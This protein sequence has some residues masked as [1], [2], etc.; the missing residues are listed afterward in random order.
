VEVVHMDGVQIGIPVFFVYLLYR[1]RVPTLARRKKRCHQLR[2]LLDT[3]DRESHGQMDELNAFLNSET[4][5]D[6]TYAQVPTMV[7]EQVVSYLDLS[8][9]SADVDTNGTLRDA[10]HR[11][12]SHSTFSGH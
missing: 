11:G 5:D 2:R 7:L 9:V 12:S 6:L 3:V 1:Y 10:P 4:S 8:I